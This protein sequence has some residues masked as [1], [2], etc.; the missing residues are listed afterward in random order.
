MCS[1]FQEHKFNKEEQSRFKEEVSILK[2]LNHPYILRLYDS[3]EFVRN[4]DKKRVLVLITE[5]MTSGTLK[6][7]VIVSLSSPSSLPPSLPLSLPPSPFPSSLS[8]FSLSL[9]LLLCISFYMSTVYIS[10]LPLCAVLVFPYNVYNI[11]YCTL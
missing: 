10:F 1:L 8:L 7:L 5:L 2:T 3:F 4:S 6:R 9:S 11:T